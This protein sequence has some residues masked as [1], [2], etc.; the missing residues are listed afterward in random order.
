M[1]KRC[2]AFLFIAMSTFTSKA[3]ELDSLASL[4]MEPEPAIAQQKIYSTELVY[5]AY[6]A[7]AYQ[8]IWQNKVSINQAIN[9][10]NDSWQEG[11][12]P[13]DYHL[14]QLNF[15]RANIDSYI[16]TLEFDVL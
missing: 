13:Q 15:M 16:N 12:Q 10:L 3:I 14:S 8:Y 11:L 4:L 5:F 1:I 7:K 9:A 2:F 6:Q